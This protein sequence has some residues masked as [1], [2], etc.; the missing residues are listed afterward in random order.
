MKKKTREKS[1]LEENTDYLLIYERLLKESR[2]WNNSGQYWLGKETYNR[3]ISLLNGN[4]EDALKPIRSE[5]LYYHKTN[6]NP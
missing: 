3:A 6:F 5:K 2:V 4:I 1:F